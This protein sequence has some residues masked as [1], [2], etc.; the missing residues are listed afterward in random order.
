MQHNHGVRSE[1]CILGAALFEVSSE[2]FFFQNVYSEDNK[3]A[4]VHLL[5]LFLFETQTG[6]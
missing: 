2:I 1:S 3:A 5:I 6:S 4:H